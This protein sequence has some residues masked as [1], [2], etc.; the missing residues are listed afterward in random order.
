V[1]ELDK[2]NNDMANLFAST[3]I[4]TIFL[5]TEKRIKRFNPATAKLLN[6]LAADVGRPFSDFAS[7]VTNAALLTDIDRVLGQD[8]TLEKEVYDERGTCYLRRIT[9]YRTQDRRIEGVAPTFV[10]ISK[11]K[12]TEE[13]LRALNKT[14]RPRSN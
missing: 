5:D 12:R 11:R 4:A 6:L 2:A 1:D 8:T 9:P 3:D 10:D 7:F 13:R 14:L